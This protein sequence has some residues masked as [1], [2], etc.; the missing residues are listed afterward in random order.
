M[1]ICWLIDDPG[2]AMGVS[3]KRIASRSEH[4]HVYVTMQEV[5]EDPLV[6]LRKIEADLFICT[7]P[8]WLKRFT[9]DNPGDVCLDLKRLKNVVACL[10]SKRAF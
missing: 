1:K 3:L 10:K 4:E 2:W 8:A 7:Y 9:F 5:I 6:E